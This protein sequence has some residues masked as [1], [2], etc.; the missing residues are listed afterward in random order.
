LLLTTK[1]LDPLSFYAFP[2]DFII[3]WVIRCKLL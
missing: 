1:L 2:L 3:W